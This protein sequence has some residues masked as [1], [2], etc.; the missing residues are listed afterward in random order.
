MPRNKYAVARRS[1][2]Y[3]LRTLIIAAAI[4]ALCLGVF[5]TGMHVSNLYI[6]TTEG[7]EKRAD[8]ILTNG[9]VLDLTNYF[10]EEFVM[11]DVALYEGKYDD[12]NISSY[13]YRLSVESVSVLPWNSRAS[14]QVVEGMASISGKANI[15][16]DTTE[17]ETPE[18]PE[19]ETVRYTIS[20]TKIGS[21]WYIS[22]ITLI[23][24]NP[25]V[26]TKPTPDYSQLE[27]YE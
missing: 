10:T 24:S 9:A 5:I 15:G 12:F 23:E 26:S 20:F 18:I 25:E 19:W 13:D 2:W 21:R 27:G 1:I 4:I 7:L 6:L 11:N 17:G 3:V 14:M 8:C 16:A 22:G